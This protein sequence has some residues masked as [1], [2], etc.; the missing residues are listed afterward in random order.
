MLLSKIDQMTVSQE[1]ESVVYIGFGHALMPS[2]LGI[3]PPVQR[4][5]FSALG[6]SLRYP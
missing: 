6:R 5:H 3:H 1:T 4:W 2:Y